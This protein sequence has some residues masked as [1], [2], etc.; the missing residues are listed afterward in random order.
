MLRMY[1]LAICLALLVYIFGAMSMAD[2]VD[3]T[4]G[5]YRILTI[6]L[7]APIIITLL[8]RFFMRN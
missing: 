2:G 1:V 4:A 8:K 5:L 7:I 3:R 6:I